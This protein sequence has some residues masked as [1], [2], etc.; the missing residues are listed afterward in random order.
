METKFIE[1]G[2]GPAGGNWGKF[3]IGRYTDDELS[4]PA[5]YPGCQGSGRLVS[6]RGA[7]DN[8]FWLMD[9]ATGEGARFDADLVEKWDL[10]KAIDEHQIWVCILYEPLLT[11]L[12]THIRNNGM[13]WW[14]LLPR[15]VDLPDAPFGIYGHRRE[16]PALGMVETLVEIRS[17]HFRRGEYCN[18]GC[19][20]HPCLTYTLAAKATEGR[21]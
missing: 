11:W 14:S 16:G 19:G 12:F 15:H 5:S 9:L 7:A 18:A 3:L 8:H 17:L 13:S 6:L 2:H 4:E 20:D 10:N 1:A 21:G